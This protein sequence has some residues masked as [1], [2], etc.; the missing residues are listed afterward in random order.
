MEDLCGV[1]GIQQESDETNK[2]LVTL[3]PDNEGID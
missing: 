2:E 1:T 3:R